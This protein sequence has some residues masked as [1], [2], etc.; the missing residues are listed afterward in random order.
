MVRG[1]RCLGVA[2]FATAVAGA[3]SAWSA[4]PPRNGVIAYSFVEQGSGYCDGCEDRPVEGLRS[5]IELVRPDGSRHRRFPC[6]TGS[7]DTCNDGTP[8]FSPDGTRLAVLNRDEIVI[9]SLNGRVLRRI[10]VRAPAVAWSPDGRRLAFT[11]NY[12][13]PPTPSRFAVYVTR[14]GGSPRQVSGARNVAPFSLSWSA[15]GLLAWEKRGRRPGVYVSGPR[16]EN[17]RRILPAQDLARLPRWSYDGSRLAYACGGFLCAVRAD[18]SNRRLLTR[19]C[20]MEFDEYGGMA[21]SPDG[22]SVACMGGRFGDLITVRLDT[23]DWRIVRRRPD[24][25]DFLPYE[26]AWRPDR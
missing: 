7:F 2:L 9:A 14:L 23:K 11:L 24:S 26:V 13:V 17:R 3:P 1:I 18:G 12:T 5:W 16:G 21:W 25:A 10:P 19:Q 8:V 6:T 15:R 20:L 4:A 22:R